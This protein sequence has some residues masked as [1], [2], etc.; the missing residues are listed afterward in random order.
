[1]PVL[2]QRTLSGA[3]CEAHPRERRAAAAPAAVPSSASAQSHTLTT[4]RRTRAAG[5]GLR[6]GPR[7]APRAMA[8]SKPRPTHGASKYRGVYWHKAGNKWQVRATLSLR[9]CVV[10]CTRLPVRPPAHPPAA[11]SRR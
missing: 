1:L 9:D 6:R 8:R 2:P 4:R 3:R 7:A 11:L 10:G 5:R